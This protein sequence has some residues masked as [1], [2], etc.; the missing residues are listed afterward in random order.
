MGK[1][2]IGAAKRAKK[3]GLK[4]IAVAGSASIDSAE[5]NGFGIDA[6]FSIS[7]GPMTL[8]EAMEKERAEDNLSFT[9]DQLVRLFGR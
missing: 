2:P 9:V 5:C 3:Y 8:E 6:V 1:A 7:N 4:T